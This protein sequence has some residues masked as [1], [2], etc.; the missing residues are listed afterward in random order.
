MLPKPT[1]VLR[2]A[3]AALVGLT[4]LLGCETSLEPIDK[5]AGLFSIYGYLNLTKEPH[6]LRIRNLK[7]PIFDDSAGGVDATVRLEHLETGATEVLNDSLVLFQGVQTHNFRSEMDI[8]PTDKYRIVVEREDGEST[9]ATATMPPVT[10]VDDRP[11]GSAICTEHF[12]FRFPNVPD[13]RFVQIKAGI[14]WPDRWRWVPID[15]P[16]VGDDGTLTVAFS[17]TT[18]IRRI[19]PERTLISIGPPKE[20]CELLS[21]KA[22]RL[23]YTHF[24]PD[25]PPDSLL[26]DPVASQ[27]EN[28]LGVF[29]G[30]HRD[31]LEKKIEMPE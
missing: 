16:T 26:A 13:P 30:L 2:C 31:T 23:A 12:E 29:G 21:K 7:D 20:Y 9:Q 24:G 19:I 22:M 8:Q 4:L 5:E 28:G 27:V 6:H 17:L 3:S 15:K 1:H 18:I 14:R 25:W 10:E 11:S